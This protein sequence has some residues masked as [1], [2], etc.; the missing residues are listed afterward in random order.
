MSLRKCCR[1]I[2]HINLDKNTSGKRSAGKPHAAFDEAGAGN[3]RCN[4][5]RQFSTLPVR[6]VEAF[7]Y[8]RILRHSPI[9]RGMQQGIQST[10]T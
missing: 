9:E 10:P 2:G 3:G 7:L 1:S 6:G 5:P 4:A 8:G